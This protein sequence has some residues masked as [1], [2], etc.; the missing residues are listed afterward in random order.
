MTRS[1]DRGVAGEILIEITV[2]GAQKRVAAIDVDSGTEVTL[3]V[4][5]ATPDAHVALL[6]RRKLAMRRPR[7]PEP[8]P[9]PG[10]YA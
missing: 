1:G 3:V 9:R 10:R 8:P 4:P 7:A 5:L 2:V 6:A